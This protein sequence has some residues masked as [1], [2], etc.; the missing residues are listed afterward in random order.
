[1]KIIKD[2]LMITNAVASDFMEIQKIYSYYVNNTT[3]SLEEESPSP[4]EMMIRWKNSVDKSLPYLVAKI[5][6]KVA[7]YAY[8]FPYRARSAYRFT[9]EESVYVSKD[10]QGLGIGHLLLSEL[11][12]ECKKKGYRQMLAVIAG[13][14]NLASIKFHQKLGFKQSGIL[15]KFGFKFDKW[16]D[17]LLMQKEL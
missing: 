7:G 8:A 4:E 3:I 15:E 9:L 17:T 13:N 14:D 6:D 1:M 11:I 5:D 16:I 12:E 10:Y 2:N